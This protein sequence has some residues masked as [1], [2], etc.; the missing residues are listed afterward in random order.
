L[1][2][3]RRSSTPTSLLR[4]SAST[5]T[6][7]VFHD[8][9]DVAGSAS[10]VQGPAF[11]ADVPVLG[12]DRLEVP[13]DAARLPPHATTKLAAAMQPLVCGRVDRFQIPDR[14][15]ELIAVS[16][17][18][19]NPGRDRSVV[20]LPHEHMLESEPARLSV[21]HAPVSGPRDRTVPTGSARFRTSFT[22]RVSACHNAPTTVKP[23]DAPRPAPARGEFS[24]SEP[25]AR[26][27]VNSPALCWRSPSHPAS[28]SAVDGLG[29]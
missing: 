3:E 17:V 15:V 18:D 20:G 16:M 26:P 9:A 8:S 10:P 11:A 13:A 4:F 29:Q 22:H 28:R 24:P 14:V 12:A 27:P 1:P 25:S 6:T 5:T 21:S 23:G 7:F 19:L 2:R